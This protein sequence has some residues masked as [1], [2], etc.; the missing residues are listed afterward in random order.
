MP[1]LP[2][3][4]AAVASALHPSATIRA[5]GFEQNTYDNAS[6][7]LVIGNVPF[8]DVRLFDPVHNPTK[9]SIH[10]H[11][12]LKSLD[13]TTPGGV[14][15]VLTSRFT[16]DASTPRHAAGTEVVSD[17]LVLRRRI[18]DEPLD[19]SW[20]Q[21]QDF[22][23]ASGQTWTG[24]TYWAANPTH[25]LGEVELT[26][27]MHGS[28][29]VQVNGG[30]RWLEALESV[31]RTALAR[32]AAYVDWTAAMPEPVTTVVGP[33]P[34]THE[35]FISVTQDGTFTYRRQGSLEPL[36]V[37][38]TQT[39]EL[40]AL[41]GL[42]DLVVKQLTLEGQSLHETGLTRANRQTL[43][44]AYDT[45]LATYGPVNRFT[46]R[47]NKNGV[48]S[49]VKPRAVA[50]LDKDPF[51]A[52]V[53]GLEE[54]DDTTEVAAKAAI[55]THMVVQA[56]TPVTR[57]AEPTDA[58]TVCRDQLGSLDLQ[59]VASLLDL[60]AD[61]AIAALGDLVFTDPTS[62]ELVPADEYLSG[63]VVTRLEEARTAAA[64]DPQL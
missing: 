47:V 61:S 55:L 29:T 3:T 37:P 7:D 35:G 26:N 28:Q 32:H 46:T 64:R 49:R 58:I 11:F 2:A 4:S 1:N 53:R 41:L 19:T 59:R 48:V 40:R 8:G 6:F 33:A 30:P 36:D 5:E 14:V 10:N 54:F 38:S 17:L 13:L 34:S 9:E 20:A 45:Y 22:T 23:T 24:N 18:E 60:D 50:I 52:Q 63:N 21:T 42:R 15:M 27:G 25:I 56:R 62:G 57:V 44:H 39:R 43:N 16:M 51:G 12:I 31:T